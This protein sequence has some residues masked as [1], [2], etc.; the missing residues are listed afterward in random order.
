MQGL[1]LLVV[2][3]NNDDCAILV[4]AIRKMGYDLEFKC[5]VDQPGMRRALEQGRWDLIISDHALPNFNAPLALETLKET[6]HDIP[7]IIVSGAIGEETCIDAMVKGA[8]DYIMK[9]NIARLGPAIERELRDASER[10]RH[11]ISQKALAASEERY[12]A[13]FET[14]FDAIITMDEHGSIQYANPGA[15]R[16]FGYSTPVLVNMNIDQLLPPPLQTEDLRSILD[17]ITEDKTRDDLDRLE[18]CGLRRN[19]NK[20]P[21]EASFGEVQLGEGKRF[22]TGIIRDVTRRKRMEREA[23]EKQRQLVHADKMSSLGILVSGVAHEINNP[24]QIIM[25][26]SAALSHIW[27]QIRPIFETAALGEEAMGI[28]SMSSKNAGEDV[29]RLLAA[30]SK[31]SDRIT[32]IVRELGDYVRQGEGESVTQI[33]ANAVVKSALSLT[34]NMLNASTT[35]FETSFGNDLPPIFAKYRRLE[36]VIINLIQNAC[37]S[38]PN[39]QGAVKI[40]TLYDPAKNAVLIR[41][42]D[43][44]RGIDE[45]DLPNISLPF[46]TTKRE[47]GG[48]GLG[49]SV[50]ASIM[51][52]LKGELLFESKLGEGTTATI[53]LPQSKP[54]IEIEDTVSGY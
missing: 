50:S 19:D 14:A 1:R 6:G 47:S 12:R 16:I 26:S 17:V 42:S 41:V 11:R 22:Y 31:A 25:S 48:T 3:D 45:K 33:H 24:N 9:D 40:S 38:L 8:S 52:E 44:G 37:Q 35:H 32:H 53:V 15:E 29:P 30:L 13:V 27:E 4:R 36:Q 23:I 51:E 21:L 39:A 28:G 20:F 46:F 49:L 54:E 7:F 18:L 10:K 34:R 43:E 2:E 5:V